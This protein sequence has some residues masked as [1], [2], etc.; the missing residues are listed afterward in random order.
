M[1]AKKL[2]DSIV[3]WVRRHYYKKGKKKKKKKIYDL[4]EKKM[5]K[6]KTNMQ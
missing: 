2:W 5:W 1:A 3:V 4:R 6:G